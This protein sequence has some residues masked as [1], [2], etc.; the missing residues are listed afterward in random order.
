[1]K[2]VITVTRN[3]NAAQ[4]VTGQVRSGMGA[5]AGAARRRVH[6]ATV[7]LAPSSG[8]RQGRCQARHAHI[9]Q[10]GLY[11]T[12][13]W[14][15]RTSTRLGPVGFLSVTLSTMWISL[16]SFQSCTFCILPYGNTAIKFG[17]LVFFALV[18]SSRLRDKPDIKALCST[19]QL[20]AYSIP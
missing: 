16:E 10:I 14:S 5:Y 11:L 20:Q 2:V 8:H 17:P 19:S 7:F 18:K 4:R 12:Q 9:P 13:P 6:L 3:I 15:L 1:M